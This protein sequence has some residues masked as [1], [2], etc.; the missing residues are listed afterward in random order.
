ML[1]FRSPVASLISSVLTLKN[2]KSIQALWTGLFCVLE[3]LNLADGWGRDWWGHFL[4]TNPPACQRLNGDAADS[5]SPCKKKNKNPLNFILLIPKYW[6]KKGK[7]NQGH[8]GS[9]DPHGARNTQRVQIGYNTKG[10]FLANIKI[11][12]HWKLK[13]TELLTPMDKRIGIFTK[14]HNI[15]NIWGKFF[16]SCQVNE[17]NFSLLFLMRVPSV[18]VMPHWAERIP[19]KSQNTSQ[20]LH[21]PSS[22]PWHRECSVGFTF[23]CIFFK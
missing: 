5:L 2:S 17:E 22:F 1:N 7:K 14:T 20:I 15:E 9:S 23:L 8:S 18:E 3:T 6:G 13:R 16:L 12:E 19:Q 4:P 10:Y 11:R 21:L